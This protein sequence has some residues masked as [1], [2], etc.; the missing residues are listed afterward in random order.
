[1]GRKAVAADE[2]GKASDIGA[3]H[4]VLFYNKTEEVKKITKG[5]A[6]KHNAKTPVTGNG[7]VLYEIE[8][9]VVDA[10]KESDRGTAHT[11]ASEVGVL[12]HLVL[13]SV[14]EEPLEHDALPC[15]VALTVRCP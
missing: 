15:L 1:M 9:P 12:A 5:P 10:T 13:K 7:M 11:A 4:R 14:V 3:T 2:N 8:A 6:K